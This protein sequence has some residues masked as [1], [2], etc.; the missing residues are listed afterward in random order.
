[1]LSTD[2]IEK[3]IKLA[4]NHESAPHEGSDEY[5]EHDIISPTAGFSSLD[6]G[7]NALSSD[8]SYTHQP[9]AVSNEEARAYYAGLP[10]RPTLVYRTGAKWFPPTGPE[11]HLRRK[12]LCPVSGHAIAKVWDDE[13]GQKVI[14]ALDDN[15]VG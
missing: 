3:C 1:M 8:S 6:L 2:F 15:G 12:V 5:E 9:H 4:L 13:L 10:S 7:G 14:D 11:A